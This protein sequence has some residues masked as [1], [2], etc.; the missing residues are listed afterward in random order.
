MAITFNSISATNRVPSTQVEINGTNALAF[1]GAEPQHVLLVGLRLSGG[2]VAEL[3]QKTILGDADADTYFGARSQLA[4]M[5]RAF[6]KVN[7]TCK[8]S[9]MALDAASGGTAATCTFAITGT[10]TETGPLTVRVGDTRITVSIASGTTATNAGV[11]LDAAIDAHATLNWT[12]TN[13][14]GTVTLTH[15]HKGLSGNYYTLEV[16]AIPAG[17]ACTPTDPSNG[18][19]NPTMSSLVSALPE[20]AFD[21]ICTGITDDT[22]MDALEAEMLRR[23]GPTVKQPGMVMAAFRGTYGA[24][25]TY[26]DARNSKYSSVTGSGLSPT[27]PWV[28]AAQVAAQDAIR[29][30]TQPNRPRNGLILPSVEAPKVADRFSHDERNLLLFDGISTLKTDS[31]SNVLI[32][33]L[34]TTSQTNTAGTADATYL[35]LETMRNLAYLYKSVL[36]LGNKYSDYLL[37]PDGTNVDPGVAVVTPSLFRGELIAWYDQMMRQGLVSDADTFAENMVC[38]INATNPERLDVQLAPTLV[39]G[40]VTLA[41]QLA[42]RL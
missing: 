7:R 23:W 26:G 17:L 5:C 41:I 2:S 36:A 14:T 21:T 3:V 16:E 18:A 34:I 4:E 11:A 24:S 12:A 40:L 39:G 35:S 20:E 42:F 15:G 9:A 33:R 10:A 6:K 1:Q 31:A 28:A 8:L 30:D 37:A 29:N 38:E 13:S 32:E 27:L 22:S 25:V 19:T